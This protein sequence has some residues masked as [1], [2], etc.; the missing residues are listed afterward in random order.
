MGDYA[1]RTA[2]VVGGSHGM[3]LATAEMLVEGG[4]RVLVTGRDAAKLEAAGR[5]LGE[6]GRALRCDVASLAEIEALA[7]AVRE[8]FGSLDLL[9]VNAAIGAFEPI[10]QVTEATFDRFFAINAKGAFFTLQR[11]APLVRDG[12]AIVVTTVTPGNASPGLGVYGG[13]KAALR[14]FAQVLAAELLPRGIRVN[15]VAPGFIATPTL[16]V[17]EAT[18]EE[19]AALEKLGEEVTP[20]KRHGTPEEVARAVLFLA[21]EATFTT[22]IELPVD[23][24]LSQIDPPQG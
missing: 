13:T 20:M 18:P 23:G 5:A 9:F 14:A 4:A 1:G 22:G 16:G 6:A 3:G 15:A 21:F 24:G 8:R 10:D 7:A 2:L 11:L 19:R 17:A 12:G